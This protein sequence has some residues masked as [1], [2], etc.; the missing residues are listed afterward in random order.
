MAR[1]LVDPTL[2]LADL[3]LREGRYAE[4][5]AQLDAA[6]AIAASPR[7][8][9]AVIR[10]R[11]EY[12]AQRGQ[13]QE[14]L[15]L[16][17]DYA[18][19]AARFL[20]PI[21]QLMAVYVDSLE[22]YARAGRVEEAVDVLRAR[23]GELEPPLNALVDIGYLMLSVEIGDT[24][25][26]NVHGRKVEALM[27][28]LSLETMRDKRAYF[29]GRVSA[30]EGRLDEAIDLLERAQRLLADS[31]NSLDQETYALELA[32]TLATFYE[33]AGRLAQARETLDYVLGRFLAHA[34]ANIVMA[35]LLRRL[36]EAEAAARHLE[37]ARE[38]LAPA[39][40]GHPLRL[41]G[42]D[43]GSALDT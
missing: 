15:A 39:D 13:E 3:A 35:R 40:E 4:A 43:L 41:A 21:D 34:Q 37:T 29:R 10:A 42:S 36:G 2:N 26:A 25:A 6:A 9:A 27:E 5:M 20:S 31:V 24:E 16:I 11:M 12:F 14:Y 17:P 8:H 19:Y 32:T 23:E 18:E 28:Q 38:A 33:R 22:H 30:L 1:G 7:Q